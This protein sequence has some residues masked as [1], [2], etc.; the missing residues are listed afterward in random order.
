MMT[1]SLLAIFMPFIGTT[2]GAGC[3]YFMK[4]KMNRTVQRILTGF[5]AGVMVAASIWSLII[6]AMEQSE[7]MGKLAF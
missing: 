5:A 4:G 2:I 3:V 7:H 6:P 1:N